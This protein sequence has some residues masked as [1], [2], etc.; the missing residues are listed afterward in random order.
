M[1]YMFRDD[2]NYLKNKKNFEMNK[3]DK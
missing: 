2:E 1:N 3:Y